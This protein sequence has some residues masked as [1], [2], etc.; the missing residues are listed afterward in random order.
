MRRAA[1]PNAEPNSKPD[2]EPDSEPNS[3]PNSKTRRPKV[4]S[5]FNQ[6]MLGQ[7]ERDMAPGMY[8]DQR[9]LMS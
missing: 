9:G 8:M 6:Y 1:V 7:T 5:G 4:V 3:D 2:T